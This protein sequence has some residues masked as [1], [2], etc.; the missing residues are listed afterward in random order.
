MELSA[1]RSVSNCSTLAGGPIV[2][3]IQVIVPDGACTM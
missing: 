1:S 2:V 3:T